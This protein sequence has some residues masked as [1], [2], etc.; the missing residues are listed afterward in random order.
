MTV[1]DIILIVIAVALLTMVVV[2]KI[3]SKRLIMRAVHRMDAK[4][5]ELLEKSE[6]EKPSQAMSHK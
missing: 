3:H 2:M 1:F 4:Y 5:T 6:S